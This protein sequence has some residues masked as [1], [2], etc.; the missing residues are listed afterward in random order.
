MSVILVRGRV[1]AALQRRFPLVD[2]LW[3]SEGATLERD[4]APSVQQ[5]PA[6]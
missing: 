5:S 6:E 3:A 4:E 2:G 1:G